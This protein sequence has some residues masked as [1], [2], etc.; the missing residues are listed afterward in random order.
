MTNTAQKITAR[1]FGADVPLVGPL[2]DYINDNGLARWWQKDGAWHIARPDP[3]RG[4][5]QYWTD[6]SFSSRDEA[7][8]AL[9]KAVQS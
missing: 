3:M 6:E 8:A 1:K 9:A 4:T 2:A 5:S 7:I